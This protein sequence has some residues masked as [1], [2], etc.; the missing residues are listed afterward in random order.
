[1]DLND[2]PYAGS[3]SFDNNKGCL[4]GTRAGHEC[5]REAILDE[6][7]N[8]INNMEDAHWVYLLSGAAGIGKSAIAHTVVR[9]FNNLG[10]LGSSFCF[11]RT[12][13]AERHP[14]IV[15]SMVACDLAD[16]D[17]QIKQ[18]LWKVVH[19]KKLLER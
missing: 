1:M 11:D 18:A 5:T 12:F 19:D 16:L 17:P 2:M 8:W 13:Q 7:T 9:R 14:D 10:C 3:A 4:A 6:I 15:F